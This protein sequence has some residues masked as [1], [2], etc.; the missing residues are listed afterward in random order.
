MLAVG[1]LET[2]TW[3]PHLV[4]FRLNVLIVMFSRSDSFLESGHT[5][6]RERGVSEIEQNLPLA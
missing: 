5:E 1:A 3:W 4:N 6:K 2:W